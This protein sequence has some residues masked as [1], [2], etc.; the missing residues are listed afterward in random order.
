[1]GAALADPSRPHGRGLGDGGMLYHIAEFETALRCNI[2]IVVVVLNNA[3]L[4]SEY[5]TE[6]RHGRVVHSVTDFRDVDF[7]A[8]ARAFGA[9][10]VRVENS[11]DIEERCA[12]RSRPINRRSSM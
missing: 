5:H 2:P 9:Y 3:C 12:A 1:M 4:A 7:A 11:T 10:G 8:V 6:K